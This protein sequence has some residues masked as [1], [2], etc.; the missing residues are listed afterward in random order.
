MSGRR[1]AFGGLSVKFCFR[2][3]AVFGT[4]PQ[5]QRDW[6][7]DHIWWPE[8]KWTAPTSGSRRSSSLLL[9]LL[10]LLQPLLLLLPLPAGRVLVYLY[11]VARI[12][13]QVLLK[14][15]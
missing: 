12:H 13:P 4:R 10:L 6:P 11:I 8:N 2:F 15:Q 9:L 3:N 1:A 7:E 14:T 5:P